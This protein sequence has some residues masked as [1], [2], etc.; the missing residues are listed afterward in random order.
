MKIDGTSSGGVAPTNPAGRRSRTR[1]HEATTSEQ[2]L[3]AAD[4]VRMRSSVAKFAEAQSAEGRAFAH[5]S[6]KRQIQ[7]ASA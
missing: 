4:T 1:T 5:C 6:P 7:C 3:P 2:S